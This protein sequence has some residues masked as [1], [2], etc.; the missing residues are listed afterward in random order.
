MGLDLKLPRNAPCP[1]G[2]GRRF[3]SCHG[4]SDAT[5][6]RRES[7]ALLESVAAREPANEGCWQAM[8][9]AI[10]RGEVGDGDIGARELPA[11][12]GA[13]RVAVVTPYYRE[14]LAVLQRCHASVAAQTIPARH[15]MVADGS[16]RDAIDAWD[17][18]HLRLDRGHADFG[19][20]PRSRG[21]LAA[22]NA[23]FDAVAYVDADNALRPRHLESLLATQ[24]ATGAAVC[25]SGRT[26]EL[27]DG[28]PVPLRLPDDA[29]GHVDT[30]CLLVGR[31]AF[32]MLDFWER[33]PRPL[34]VIGDRVFVRALRARGF[35]PACSGAL[36]VRYTIRDPAIY[37]AMGIPAGAGARAPIDFAP[38]FGWYRSLGAD[39]RAA[40]D[41]TLGFPVRRLLHDL[42]A[43]VA[44]D[45]RV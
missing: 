35:E 28:R 16:P 17:V 31:A 12:A 6:T 18:L 43:H 4:A 20:T 36:T 21:G 39:A 23:G 13:L 37:A 3:K 26:L 40:L 29:Q 7:L 33:Y 19:D 41:A 22:A 1:C 30:N 42:A 27:P 14:D 11:A 2:S 9:E 45:L 25:R 24:L 5:L 8:Q 15:V 10:A 44:P 34:S 38:L 32:G